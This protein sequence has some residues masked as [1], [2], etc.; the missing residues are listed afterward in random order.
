V[1]TAGPACPRCGSP[2]EPGVRFCRQCGAS[3][4]TPAGPDGVGP[5][6]ATTFVGRRYELR[7][8]LGEGARKRV[9]LV[10][11]HLLDADVAFALLKTEGLDEAG[12]ARVRRE[13]QAM[14]RLRDH[15]HVVSVYDVG[16]EAGVPYI[17]SEYLS[18]GSVASL[19]AS[20]P[21]HRLD[22]DRAVRIA[23]QVCQALAHAHARGVIHRDLKPGNVWLAADGT[24]KLGDFGLAVAMDRSRLT[25]EGMMVGTV[26]YMPPEQALGSAADSRSDLYALGTMLYEMVCGRPPFV[27]EDA[28]SVISQHINTPPVAP[29]WHNASVPPA[30][31]ALILR[32]LAKSP[33]DRPADAQSVVRSLIAIAQEPAEAEAASPA[34]QNPLDRLAGGVFVGREQEIAQL[35]S[36][37]EEALSGRG[38]LVLL[39]GEPGIG[40]TRTA[41]ELAIYARLRGA[42][43]LMGRCW[44]GEGAPAY[45][46]WVQVIRSYVHDRE[47]QALM[48]VMGA[49]AADIAQVVSE[50]RE[51][52]PGLPT[53]PSL[54]PEQAR[55]RLFDSITTFLK[56]ASAAQPLVLVLDDLHWADKPSLLLLQFLTSELRGARALILGT[57]RDVELGRQHPLAQ[58]L[59]ELARENLSRRILLRGLTQGDVAR[60]IQTTAG[61]SPPADLV[62]AVYRETEGNPFFVNEIVRLL[63]ADGRL[64]HPQDVQHWSVSIPQGVREVIGRR[65]DHLSEDCNRILGVSSVIGRE[66]HLD[67]LER[68]SESPGEDLLELLEEAAGARV[69]AEVAGAPGRYTFS[70]ALIRQTLYDELSATRRVRL[71]RRIA[72]VLESLYGAA[73][74]HHLVELAHHFLQAASGGDVS[75]AV[76]YAI[77]AGE[78]AASTLAYEDAAEQYERALQALELSE[79][80][81][82]RRRCDLL[83]RC[84]EAHLKAGDTE[85]AR[86]VFRR[87]AVVSRTLDEPEML[88]RAAMG[89]GGGW[90]GWGIDTWRLDKELVGLLEEADAALG[91]KDGSLKAMVLG[92]LAVA[93]YW[94]DT[95][96]RRMALAQHAVEMAERLGDENALAATLTTR[97]YALWGPETAQTRLPIATEIVRLASRLGDKELA[98]MG[99]RF[100]LADLLELGDIDEA[101]REF[102]V[103]A[104]LAEDLRQPYSLWRVTMFRAMRAMLDGRM[105]EAEQLAGQ[106]LAIGQRTQSRNAAELYFGQL[107]VIRAAQGRLGELEPGVRHFAEQYPDVPAIQSG[108]AYVYA[109]LGRADEARRYFERAAANDFLDFPPDATWTVAMTNLADTAAFIGDERRAAQLYDLLSPYAGRNIVLGPGGA[110]LGPA[111]HF[112]GILAATMGRPDD[113]AAHFEAGLAMSR[114]MGGRPLV[115]RT[116]AAFAKVHLARGDRSGGLSLLNHALATARETGLTGLV[117]R[118]LAMKLEIQGASSTDVTSSIDAVA[119]AVEREHPDL[120]RAAAPDGTVTI[121]FTDIERFTDLTERLGDRRAQEVL[122]AHN[123]IVR[124]RVAAHTGYE[125]RCQGDGF[126]IAFTGAAQ[127]LACAVEIQR[128]IEQA[129]LPEPIRVRIGVHTGEALREAGD[130][131]GRSVILAARI[132]STAQGGEILASGLTRDLVAARGEFAFGPPREVALKGLSGTHEVVS[133]DWSRRRDQAPAEELTT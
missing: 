29:R 51:R 32:L 42:Q 131:S 129:E 112:L 124:R 26:A 21:D 4:E 130:F 33:D 28:V 82:D 86:E 67:I 119:A 16:E 93:I 94:S 8:P 92:R 95:A 17:V 23:D 72:Q 75:K 117:E 38:S 87:A 70:H 113:A 100:R 73:P 103:L 3:I 91:E 104:R 56:N 123:A 55:F 58:T 88:A 89:F 48:S 37:F 22:V 99:H 66:F 46:P 71:H 60:F 61:I 41:E 106:A 20:I 12:L 50:V 105:D 31:E 111:D 49:G 47:P 13:A 81:D 18:G 68:V 121:L 84:G 10:H 65:L 34:E 115:A 132:A 128:G 107:F 5:I 45:W 54:E 127:A 11:D 30:L 96:E 101:D 64:E 108:L 126:M 83:L 44:E 102:S 57:Y 78:R 114:A 6:P 2:S 15:V 77:R 69:I 90:V 24:A 19:L 35:R 110:C 97:H 1:L 40:K 14:G 43:A 116:E 120:G 98:L 7:R 79:P 9:H 39:V 125:V 59:G 76:D 133:V 36:S 80:V 25:L 85:A 109:E 122:R 62:T 27:G 53:P 74:E 118:I 63:V 52:L